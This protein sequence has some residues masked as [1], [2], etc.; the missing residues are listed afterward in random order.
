MN[1]PRTYSADFSLSAPAKSL[2]R[3]NLPR[4]GSCRNASVISLRKFC[5][6]RFESCRSWKAPTMVTS[7]RPP[8]MI[9]GRIHTEST[10]PATKSKAMSEISDTR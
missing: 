6:L 5:W 4:S 9:A 10:F 3:V 2:T 8:T 1:S 7:I